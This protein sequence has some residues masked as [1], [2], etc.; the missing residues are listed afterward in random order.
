M[1]SN[2]KTLIDG[3]FQVGSNHLTVDTSN[4]YVGFNTATP[5]NKIDVQ[6]GARTGTHSIDKPLYVTGVTSTSGAEF[7]SDDGTAGIGIG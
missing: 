1:S 6:I 3:D 5:Q 7:V 4:N 2:K